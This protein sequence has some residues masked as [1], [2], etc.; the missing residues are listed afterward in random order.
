V[1]SC[2]KAIEN[3]RRQERTNCVRVGLGVQ[4]VTP[5]LAPLGDK[6]LRSSADP[7]VATPGDATVSAPGDATS[8]P[9]SGWNSRAPG[10]CKRRPSIRHQYR[11]RKKAGRRLHS[12]SWRR[13]PGRR[14]Q[15]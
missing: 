11:Q 4:F 2:R 9:L 6:K 15:S 1:F 13:V 8:T 7:T 5:V 10:G 12:L 3:M 14:Q